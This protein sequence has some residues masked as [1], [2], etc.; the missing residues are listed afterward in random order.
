MR[1]FIVIYLLFIVSS[2]GMA[3]E[4]QKVVDD[5]TDVFPETYLHW[6][7]SELI[8]Y[9][10][11]FVSDTG[12]ITFNFSEHKVTGSY[13]GGRKGGP[14]IGAELPSLFWSI[15]EKGILNLSKDPDT[16]AEEAWI[17]IEE[18]DDKV[19]IYSNGHRNTYIRSKK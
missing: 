14:Y 8:G 7:S 9:K 1:I 12:K 6:K 3:A 16:P 10:Y 5:D 2:F 15:D 4:N 17:K 11:T 13:S 19:V 18:T